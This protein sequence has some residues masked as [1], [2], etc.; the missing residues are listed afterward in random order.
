MSKLLLAC[1]TIADEINLA[2]EKTGF[3]YPV[4]WVESGLH[5]DPSSLSKRLQQELGEIHDVEDVLLG[6]GFCGNSLIGITP[7]RFRLII[8]KVDD[9]ITLLLGSREK[10]RVV[11]SEAGTYFLTRGWLLHEQNIWKEYK[12]CV[13]RHGKSKTDKI[14][15]MILA[16]YKRLGIIETGAYNLEEFLEKAKLMSEDLKLNCEVIPGTLSFVEKLLTGPWDDDF[17]KINPGETVTFD[18]LNLLG[19]ESFIQ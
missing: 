17:I 15:K 8:P 5:I 6:F 4:R 1:N 18:H 16:H 2:I 14:Y 3:N 9:C 7:P 12:I 11:S 10:R 19:G 13:K